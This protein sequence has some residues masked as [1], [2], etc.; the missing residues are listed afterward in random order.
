[1]G[2]SMALIP[3]RP[4]SAARSA[5]DA[6]LRGVECVLHLSGLC[7]SSVRVVSVLVQD[8]IRAIVGEDREKQ[9]QLEKEVALQDKSTKSEFAHKALEK[10]GRDVPSECSQVLWCVYVCACACV[11]GRALNIRWNTARNK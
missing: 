6:L 11:C 1:M 9:I 8:L 5:I 4:I 3:M 2:E 10:P 7:C